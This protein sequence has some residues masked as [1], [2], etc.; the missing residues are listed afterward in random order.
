M[1]HYA[2]QMTDGSVEIMQ[3][4]AHGA[5]DPITGKPVLR[6]EPPPEAYIAKWPEERRA[7]VTGITRIDP[8]NVPADRTFRGAWV[9]SGNGIDHD[10]AKARAIHRDRMRAA[11]APLL[12]A[13]DVEYQRADERG[14]AKAKADIAARKQTLRDAPADPRIEAANTID[15]LKA[16]TLPT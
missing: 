4:L 8:A 1:T 15:E 12:A 6:P 2:I 5:P 9:F 14:D 11:R 3:T 16:I 10:M 13:L 7:M